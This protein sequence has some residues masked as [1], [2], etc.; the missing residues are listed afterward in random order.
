MNVLGTLGMVELPPVV[1]ERGLEEGG[2]EEERSERL[3][4]RDGG[5]YREE[6][7]SGERA[8]NERKKED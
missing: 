6:H 2:R 1:R 7:K 5:I 3:N 8:S 4:L